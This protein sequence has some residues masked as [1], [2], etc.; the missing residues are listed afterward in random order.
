MVLQG[1]SGVGLPFV[2]NAPVCL[3][4]PLHDDTHCMREASRT[5][6]LTPLPVNHRSQ[7]PTHLLFQTTVRGLLGSETLPE[8]H[9]TL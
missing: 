1:G 2:L 6:Q 9:W 7:L 4:L 5:P 3:A 8:S